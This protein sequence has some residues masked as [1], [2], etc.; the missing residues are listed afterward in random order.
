MP[1]LT[2]I[3]A[4]GTRFEVVLET[5][6]DIAN[7][8]IAEAALQEVTDGHRRWSCFASDS[9]ITRINEDGHRGPVPVDEVTFELLCLCAKLWRDT[10]GFFDPALGSRMAK[11]GHHP[12][13]GFGETPG[14][15]AVELDHQRARVRLLHRSVRLDLG[16]IAKGFA[17]DL[18]R[19]VL[20]AEG[21]DSALMHGGSSSVMAIGSPPDES[22]WHIALARSATEVHL[23][24]ESLAISASDGRQ[25]DTGDGHVLLPGGSEGAPQGC[26]GVIGE[27]AAIADGWATAQVAA[28]GELQLPATYREASIA[29]RTQV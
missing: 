15:L 17:L 5:G 12:G 28:G 18:A 6:S 8:A 26:F 9:I 24:D 27:S 20:V 25:T 11:L 23:C 7:R 19:E 14:F 2:A 1:Y 22:H 16:A 13:R 10:D 3:E 29:T 4:M 21:V